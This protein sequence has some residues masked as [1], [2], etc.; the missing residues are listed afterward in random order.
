MLMAGQ[1]GAS[2]QAWL[3]EQPLASVART[4]KVAEVVLVGVPL[5]TPALLI[6]AQAGSVPLTKLNV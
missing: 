6:V 5:S 1:T 3:I 2:V 4:V